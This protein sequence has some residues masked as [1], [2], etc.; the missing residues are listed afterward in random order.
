MRMDRFGLS[1]TLATL[2]L[3]LWVGL[4][5]AHGSGMSARCEASNGCSCHGSSPNANGA[6]TVTL[7][8]PTVVNVGST[9]TYTLSVSGGPSGSTGGFNLCASGGTL[10]PGSGCRML[11]G[12][13]T[14]TSNADRF[15]T[16]QW[17]AP[18][19][20]ATVEFKA[21][22]LASNGSGSSGDSWNWYGGASGAPF[23][24]TVEATVPVLPTSWGQLKDRY[25]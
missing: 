4:L 1:A 19:S 7:N 18:A 13:L 6:V 3:C 20:G 9:N 22:C 14:H 11:S 17:T 25:R 15:W 21:T 8:G 24:I 16:F 2:T 23:T 10:V 5:F 12:E